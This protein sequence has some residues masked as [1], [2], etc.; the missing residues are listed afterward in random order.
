MT[1]DTGPGTC[2]R[3]GRALGGRQAGEAQLGSCE[4]CQALL[5]RQSALMP[6]LEALS[7]PLLA[8]FDADAALPALPDRSGQTACP[9]CARAME[10]A[11]YCGAHLVFFDRCNRCGL[12]WI[13]SEELGAMS[14]MWARMEKRSARARAQTEED[15]SGMD[16]LACAAR[17]RRVVNSSLRLLR[18]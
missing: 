7:A 6:T 13:G 16:A 3:C 9:G 1:A 4:A 18:F 8:D 2:P 12:L 15:L 10:K 17:I 14:L 5:V 11:D